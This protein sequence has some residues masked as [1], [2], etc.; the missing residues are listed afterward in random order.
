AGRFAEHR[1]VELA[2]RWGLGACFL[3]YSVPLWMR[4]R[5]PRLF[6][7]NDGAGVA[8]WGRLALI[9]LTV[10]PVLLLA[11]AP[12][13]GRPARGGVLPRPPAAPL[14]E[15]ALRTLVTTAPLAM[16][17]LGLIGHA[18]REKSPGYAFAVGLGMHLAVSLVVRNFHHGEPIAAW[19]VYLAQA[20]LIAAA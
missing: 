6:G 16:V 11:V 1:T 2:L 18:L 3:L 13:A 7:E 14:L 5:L 12:P 10:L 19:W 4:N 17:C 20:N 15:R 8:A 9:V